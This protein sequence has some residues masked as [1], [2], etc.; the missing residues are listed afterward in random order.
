VQLRA[1]ASGQLFRAVYI[2]LPTLVQMTNLHMLMRRMNCARRVS[3]DLFVIS[4]R[5]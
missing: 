5:D 1:P 4:I 2:R 3:A